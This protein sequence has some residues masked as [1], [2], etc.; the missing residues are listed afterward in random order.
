MTEVVAGECCWAIAILY[1]WRY[2]SGIVKRPL[3]NAESSSPIMIR[4]SPNQ[5]RALE[6]EAN[7]VGMPLGG[8]MRT[9]C[10]AAAGNTH[11]AEQ[12]RRGKQKRDTIRKQF[13]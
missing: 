3:L 2:T 4:L 13:K 9:I 8:W 6:D 1:S 10:L 11:L 5:R 7:A 12:I